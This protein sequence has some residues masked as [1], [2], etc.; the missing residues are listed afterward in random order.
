ML[1]SR[2]SYAEDPVSV[3]L[4]DAQALYRVGLRR[5][6]TAMGIA[7]IGEASNGRDA[8]RLA[9]E[10]RPDVIVMDTD[11]PDVS[12]IEITSSL[13]CLPDAP[14][15]LILTRA[16]TPDVLDALI[17][18]AHS[19]LF[20]TADASELVNGIRR[21][22]I[23]ETTLAPT[24]ARDLVDRLREL[25]SV[26]CSSVPR[27]HAKLTQRECDVLRL[28]AGGR[29][30]QSIGAELYISPSTVKHHVAAILDK[31][32]ASNRAQAAAE[33]VRIGLA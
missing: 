10:L 6:L 32:G 26:R 24:V 12:G 2:T 19:Y 22:A 27:E 13:A 20:K 1:H 31:L 25:E 8:I 33:A 29:D 17:A 28:V 23:G 15:V 16:Q 21:A 3:L 30:N 5:V 11:L 7:I 14:P 4:V 18:G 9:S